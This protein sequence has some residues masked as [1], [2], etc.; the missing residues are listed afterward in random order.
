MFSSDRTRM[1]RV[2]IDAWRKHQD[3][4]PMQPLETL[5]AGIVRQHPEY[6]R[7]L[8]T[9][10][11]TV[12]QEFLPEHGQ[13]NPFLHMGMHISLQEQLGTDRPAGIR[14]L[15]QQLAARTGDDHQAE[16]QLMECLGLSLWQAQ[17][18]G[19]LPDDQAYLD[20][21]RKLLGKP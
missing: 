7:L 2:F 21:V 11:Q 13:S 8:E 20:C 5:I 10:S 9:G 15:Y 6:Q 3:Q 1:R 18:S 17:R 12:D 19:G 14:G 4:Q 16:H